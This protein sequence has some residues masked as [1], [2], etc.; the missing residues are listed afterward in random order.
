MITGEGWYQHVAQAF[1]A[2]EGEAKKGRIQFYGVASSSLAPNEM[3]PDP[4]QLEGFLM[5]AKRSMLP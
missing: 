5:H 3:A 4:V 2:L 1:E